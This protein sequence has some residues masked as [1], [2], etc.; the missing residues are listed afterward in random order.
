VQ[1]RPHQQVISSSAKPT[2]GRRAGAFLIQGC[3]PPLYKCISSPSSAWCVHFSLLLGQR[4]I[5]T[6][7]MGH[8][9]YNV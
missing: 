6:L 2:I 5:K 4:A 8:K 9:F 3:P 1:Q 7:D